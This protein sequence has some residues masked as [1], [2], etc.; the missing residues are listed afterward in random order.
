M[1]SLTDTSCR[2]RLCAGTGDNRSGLVMRVNNHICPRCGGY[3]QVPPSGDNPKVL[4][5]QDR[6]YA[7]GN[8]IVT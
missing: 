4:T 7:A 1:L 3:G 6:A 5:E 2:C 8:G